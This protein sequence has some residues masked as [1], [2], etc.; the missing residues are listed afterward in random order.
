M[1]RAC[2][3]CVAICT[4]RPFTGRGNTAAAGATAKNTET[5]T[6]TNEATAPTIASSIPATTQHY[7]HTHIAPF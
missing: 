6:C 3:V 1:A 7:P 4:A 5:R 2:G